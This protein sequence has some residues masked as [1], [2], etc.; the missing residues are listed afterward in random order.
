MLREQEDVTIT[1]DISE[2]LQY[3]PDV[4]RGFPDKMLQGGP[5]MAHDW[6]GLAAWKLNRGRRSHSQHCIETA[7]RWLLANRR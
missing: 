2:R 3:S 6:L 1:Q 7:P 5:D 4:A